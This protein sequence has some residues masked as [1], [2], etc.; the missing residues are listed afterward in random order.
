VTWIAPNDPG[1]N[2]LMVVVQT[3]AGDAL[4]MDCDGVDPETGEVSLMPHDDGGY[5]LLPDNGDEV[6]SVRCALPVRIFR[7]G[8][9]PAPTRAVHWHGPSAALVPC[10]MPIFPKEG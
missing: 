7:M 3:D 1:A 9:Q 10:G 6:V 4:L 8:E 5:V 2:E